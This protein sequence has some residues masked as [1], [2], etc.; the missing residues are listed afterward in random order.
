[1]SGEASPEGDQG[2]VIHPR[3]PNQNRRVE[4]MILI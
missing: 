4:M 2:I 3:H 1:M